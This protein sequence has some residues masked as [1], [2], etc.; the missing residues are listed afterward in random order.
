LG[1]IIVQGN[2]LKVVIAPKSG[3]YQFAFTSVFAGA[4]K[5]ASS[6]IIVELFRVGSNTDGDV[7]GKSST[8]AEG[9]LLTIAATLKLTKGDKIVL[10]TTQGSGYEIGWASFSG[11]LLQEL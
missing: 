2:G 10:A 4:A 11:S 7:V 3:V 1:G 6:S 9:N 8:T 5:N